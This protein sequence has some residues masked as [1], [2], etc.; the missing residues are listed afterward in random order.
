MKWCLCN[1][2]HLECHLYIQGCLFW[3]KMWRFYS[4]RGYDHCKGWCGC[5]NH[6]IKYTA[7]G[8]ALQMDKWFPNKET[9]LTSSSGAQWISVLALSSSSS[10]T[11]ILFLTQRDKMDTLVQWCESTQ[12]PRKHHVFCYDKS[13]S[14]LVFSASPLVESELKLFIFS[15]W[16]SLVFYL[17]KKHKPSINVR[18]SPLGMKCFKDFSWAYANT[19]RDVQLNT[20]LTV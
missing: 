6:R 10:S 18:S 20:R 2:I 19:V 13:L 9:R 11:V 3:V 1:F 7:K 16:H 5:C 17:K 14:E 4:Q 15:V 12:Q 8:A